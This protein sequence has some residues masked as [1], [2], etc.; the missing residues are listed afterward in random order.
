M[1]LFVDNQGCGS[2]RGERDRCLGMGLAR[3]LG[4]YVSIYLRAH[5][6]CSA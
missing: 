1:C 6:D 3:R 4:E 5:G 2:G